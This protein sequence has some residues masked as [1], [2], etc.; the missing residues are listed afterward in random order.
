MCGDFSDAQIVRRA[1]KMLEVF[2]FKKNN[3]VFLLCVQLIGK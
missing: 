2:H 1:F 3:I